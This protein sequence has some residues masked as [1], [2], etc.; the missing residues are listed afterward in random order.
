[1]D[2]KRDQR[3]DI[4]VTR[5]DKRALKALAKRADI[6]VSQY[7]INFIRREAKLKGIVRP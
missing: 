6:S 3:V 5:Q 4:R 1:M 2:N 7:L